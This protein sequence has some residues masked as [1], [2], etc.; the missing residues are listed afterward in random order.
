MWDSLSFAWIGLGVL[1]QILYK[2]ESPKFSIKEILLD[3]GLVVINA[4]VKQCFSFFF[5]FSCIQHRCRVVESVPADHRRCCCN[6]ECRSAVGIGVGS[7]ADSPCAVRQVA[8]ALQMSNHWGDVKTSHAPNDAKEVPRA[9]LTRVPRVMNV[10][11]LRDTCC[12]VPRAIKKENDIGCRG[13]SVGGLDPRR[14]GRMPE[15]DGRRRRAEG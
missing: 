3:W 10:R 12:R 2:Q 8:L 14:G 13:Q 6:N 11:V 4:L 1:G 9:A 7:L 5:A 15:A